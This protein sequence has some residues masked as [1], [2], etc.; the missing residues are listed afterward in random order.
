MLSEMNEIQAFLKRFWAPILAGL[1]LVTATVLPKVERQARVRVVISVGPGSEPLMQAGEL[2]VLPADEFRVV[3]LPWTSAVARALGNG[4]GDVGVV[5]LD[6]VLRMREGG[7]RLRVLMVLDESVGADALMVREGIP[8]VSG[9]RGKAI[10]VDVRSAGAYLLANALEEAGMTMKD[11][12]LVQLIHSEM[13][14]AVQAGRVDAVVVADPWLRQMQKKGMRVVY[15]S[16][17]LAVPVLH[18]LVASERSHAALSPRFAELLRAQ[19]TMTERIRAD[20]GLGGRESLL[21]RERLS[22]SEFAESL[23]RVRPIDLVGNEDLLSGNRSKL[24]IMAEKMEEQ[25]L[26]HGLMLSRANDSP[27]IDKELFR[28]VLK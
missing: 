8:D 17:K 9:L 26:R 2:N 15:D 14:V 10:G 25:M 5:T 16:T 6:G 4:A 27:W 20:K 28:E 18:L 12:E 24:E 3:E 7:Q 23:N 1:L 19:L 22:A 21:R 13:Q 11:V